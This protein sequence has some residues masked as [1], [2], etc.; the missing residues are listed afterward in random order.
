MKNHY[1]LTQIY[2]AWDPYV[3]EL[4]QTIKNTSSGLLESFL[5]LTVTEEDFQKN[6]MHSA[7]AEMV[8][9]LL[10]FTKRKFCEIVY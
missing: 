9:R 10:S 7:S 1:M 3:R 8:L 5:G 2:L 6:N 4:K